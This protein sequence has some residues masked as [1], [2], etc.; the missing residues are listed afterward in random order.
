MSNIV[1]AS[2]DRVLLNIKSLYKKR[3]MGSSTLTAFVLLLPMTAIL[4]K[5]LPSYVHTHYSD[6]P[7]LL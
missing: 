3:L 6:N 5:M 7:A 4:L 1:M 2:G